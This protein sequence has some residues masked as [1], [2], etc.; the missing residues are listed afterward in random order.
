MHLRAIVAPG[1]TDGIPSALLDHMPHS[2]KRQLS[3][4]QDT[5]SPIRAHDVPFGS[6]VWLPNDR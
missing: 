3:Y 2:R 5:M 4:L 1:R 6:L